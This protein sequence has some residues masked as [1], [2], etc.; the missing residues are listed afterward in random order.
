MAEPAP[1]N[2]APRP[3][4]AQPSFLRVVTSPA[5]PGNEPGGGTASPRCPGPG[6]SPGALHRPR[7]PG[8]QG[9]SAKW[10][11]DVVPNKN[12]L[13]PRRE[14][15]PPGPRTSPCYRQRL[16][17]GPR[18]GG[19]RSLC[20]RQ[21]RYNSSPDPSPAQRAPT[22][23]RSRPESCPLPR[24]TGHRRALRTLKLTRTASGRAKNTQMTGAGLDVSQPED[25]PPC[26][27]SL[28][29]L[30]QDKQPVAHDRPP[31]H[32]EPAFFLIGKTEMGTGSA[33][34]HK[35]LITPDCEPVW[36]DDI[37][38]KRCHVSMSR[39]AVC[40]VICQEHGTRVLPRP[41]DHLGFAVSSWS[42]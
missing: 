39:R 15:P 7:R 4:P 18:T 12:D 16:G 28:D 24:R 26:R 38:R 25:R 11:R 34:Q 23:L 41:R 21:R 5:V 9:R 36:V 13:S 2:P 10:A 8:W 17:R 29:D 40:L 22:R 42:G 31:D 3:G 14:V 27:R 1:G 20:P 32:R 33:A 37:A 6:T 35:H 19:P 30:P